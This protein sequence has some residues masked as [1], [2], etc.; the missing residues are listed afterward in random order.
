MLRGFLAGLA[1]QL[2]PEDGEGWLILS[3]LAEHLNCVRGTSCWTGSTLQGSSSPAARTPVP[4]TRV[5]PILPTRC[6]LPARR[7]SPRC[8]G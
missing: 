1:A 3:D 8:G 2:A 6:T 4:S 7:R 5:R